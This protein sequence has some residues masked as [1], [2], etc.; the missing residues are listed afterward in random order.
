MRR[1]V[2]GGM[3][4]TKKY[5]GRYYREADRDLP[6]EGEVRAMMRELEAGNPPRLRL[7]RQMRRMMKYGRRE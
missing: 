3:G 4:T 5:I 1:I 7:N 6:I 2:A